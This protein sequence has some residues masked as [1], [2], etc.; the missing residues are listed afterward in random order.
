MAAETRRAP[1]HALPPSG[2]PAGPMYPATLGAYRFVGIS[3]HRSKSPPWA[4]N[5]DVPDRRQPMSTKITRFIL[6]VSAA[7][8][9]VPAVP[10][11]SFAIP[12]QSSSTV[13]IE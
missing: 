1:L 7:V 4:P 8:M 3:R 13:Q 11:S 6:G 10:A 5:D 12:P 2:R 9:L